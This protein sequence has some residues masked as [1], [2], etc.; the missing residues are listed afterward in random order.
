L[1]SN[2]IYIH[3]IISTVTTAVTAVVLANAVGYAA[4]VLLVLITVIVTVTVAVILT[5]LSIFLITVSIIFIAGGLLLHH[6]IQCLCCVLLISQ[7]ATP[8]LGLFRCSNDFGWRMEQ[9][10][11]LL[12]C[13]IRG[14][15]EQ[16]Q[17][18]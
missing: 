7:Q 16:Q 13:G 15:V 4:L 3:V 5:P 1:P 9:S 10:K 6:P 11:Q 12:D 2:P 18:G 17:P 14:H 8:F